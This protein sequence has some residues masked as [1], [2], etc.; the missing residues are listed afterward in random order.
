VLVCHCN[1]VNDHRIRAEIA[2]GARDEFDIARACGAGTD[3]G[4]CVP[5]ISRLLDECATCPLRPAAHI[6]AQPQA[7]VA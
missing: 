4:G 6:E 7:A 1:V 2:R 3:C 5:A